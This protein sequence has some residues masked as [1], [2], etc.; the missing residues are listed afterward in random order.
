MTS[1]GAILKHGLKIATPEAPE[2]GYKFGKGV[3][4]CIKITLHVVSLHAN[5]QFL[6]DMSYKSSTYCDPKSSINVGILLL[7]EVVTRTPG[8]KPMLELHSGRSDAAELAEEQGSIATW[9]RG[10]NNF[11]RWKDGVCISRDL[12]GTMLPET[13]TLIEPQEDA[14]DRILHNVNLHLNLRCKAPNNT[15]GIRCLRRVAG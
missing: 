8:S 4:F 1:I 13:Y 10:L 14:G 7:C 6:A 12:R 15:L 9:A 2:S 3:Y 5:V 11:K